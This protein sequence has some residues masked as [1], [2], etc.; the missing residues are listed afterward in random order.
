MAPRAPTLPPPHPGE[1]TRSEATAAFAAIERR[2][3]SYDGRFWF[4]V[5]TTGIYCRPSCSARA[6]K[7]ENIRLF[8]TPENARAAGFRACRRCDPDGAV[9]GVPADSRHR[10]AIEAACRRLAYTSDE[11]PSLAE[12]ASEAQLSPF[13]FQRLFKAATGVTPKAFA[14]ACR[15]ARLQEGLQSEVRVIDAVFAAGYNTASRFYDAVGAELGMSPSEARKGGRGVA[16]EFTVAPC[17]LGQVLVAV[18]DKGIA[19]ILLGDDEAALEL[20]LRERF[21]RAELQAAGSQLSDTVEQVVALVEAPARGLDLPL[22][23]RGTAF[24][25]LVWLELRKIPPGMTTTYTELA[26]RVGRPAAVR[27]VAGACAA[28]AHA[29]AVPCH[30]VLRSNGDVSGYRW[31]V[32]RKRALLDRERKG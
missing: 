29:V 6:A 9:A 30:R 14:V 27:A 12:L 7:Q 22:D 1:L 8:R 3:A 18:T 31:G 13:H 16:L 2:D 24:Q 19:A 4:A 32:P 15:R 23:I 5:V 17:S 20:E 25:Q 28:N 26:R 11:T 10:M 21:P